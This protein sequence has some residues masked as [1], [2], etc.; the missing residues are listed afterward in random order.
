MWGNWV[1]FLCKTLVVT[2]QCH[3]PP[4]IE[5]MIAREKLILIICIFLCLEIIYCNQ[6]LPC[7]DVL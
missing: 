7:R 4:D 2:F 5:Q 1:V 6:I 3:G